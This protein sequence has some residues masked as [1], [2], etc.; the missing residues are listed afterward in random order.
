[1]HY[2]AA[3]WGTLL[4]LTVPAEIAHPPSADAHDRWGDGGQIPAWVKQSCCGENDVH[5]YR[6]EAVKVTAR[7]YELPNYPAVIPM[8]E[9]LPS[10]SNDGLYWVFF[11]KRQDGAAPAVYCFYVPPTGV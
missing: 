1:M 8:D 6:P 4:C 9:A 2:R 10:P 11:A 5:W 7:G 3:L